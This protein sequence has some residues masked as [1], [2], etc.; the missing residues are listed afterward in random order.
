MSVALPSNLHSALHTFRRT[1]SIVTLW[2][3]FLCINQQDIEERSQQVRMMRAIF[4]H[5]SEVLI[6]LGPNRAGDYLGAGRVAQV[7]QVSN[8][9]YKCVWHNDSSDEDMV[10]SYLGEF[11]RYEGGTTERSSLDVLF[12]PAKTD[13]LKWSQDVFGAFYVLNRL[14]QGF[15]T[16]EL[17]VLQTSMPSPRQASWSKKIMNAFESFADALWWQRTWVI[18]ETVLAKKATVYLGHM[19]APWTMLS[20]GA[21]A[22]THELASS[23]LMLI[24]G[25]DTRSPLSSLAKAIVDIES[26]RVAKVDD[27]RFPF[28]LLLRRFRTKRSS[29]PR[30]KV[31]ALLG[32]ANQ[33]IQD[34]LEPNYNLT[35]EEVMLRTTVV[36]ISESRSL[37]ILAGRVAGPG[38]ACSWTTDWAQFPVDNEQERTS[39]L[40]LYNA[41]GGLAGSLRLHGRSLLELS[42]YFV[43]TI[44]FLTTEAPEYGTARM[45]GVLAMWESSWEQWSRSSKYMDK[46]D[47][48][49]RT[50]SGDLLYV[51][52][53]E[54]SP[55]SDQKCK[56]RRA[57]SKGLAAFE[58]WKKDDVGK[59]NRKSSFGPGGLVK[60]YVEPEEL[61]TLKNSFY[62]AV[63]AASA[64]RRFFITTTG[65]IGIGPADIQEGDVL[66]IVPGSRVPLILRPYEF[67]SKKCSLQPIQ[68]LYSESGHAYASAQQCASY[69]ESTYPLV[70]DAYVHGI[71][72]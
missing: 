52:P 63:L 12:G 58:A 6:W 41:S 69:H 38:H 71:M 42:G 24:G 9:D 53:T 47:A 66:Y 54:R 44:C 36:L 20:S 23:D 46:M 7:Y 4:S 40:H 70:G 51:E 21:A 39:C 29:D 34:S 59:R 55:W 16:K 18:Q 65:F 26:I 72:N 30:D 50:V 37:E 33:Q 31:F 43:D 2:V 17:R 60:S 13:Q 56:Y 19:S 61:S 68:N 49:W 3:D 22:Y 11:G 32:I 10:H 1:N 8:E 27:L 14:A 64:S 67:R 57:D 15:R 5:S 45:R 62:Y 35:K 28:L 48:F 25:D